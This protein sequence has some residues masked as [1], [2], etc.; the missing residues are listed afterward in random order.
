M[1]HVFTKY[2]IQQYY[3]FL[4]HGLAQFFSLFLLLFLVFSTILSDNKRVAL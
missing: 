1:A 2:Q 4:L 3:P